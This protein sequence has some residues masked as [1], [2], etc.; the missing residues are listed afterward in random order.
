MKRD[1]WKD[2]CELLEQAGVKITFS[3]YCRSGLLARCECWRCRESRSEPVTPESNA[4]SER[5]ADE[6]DAKHRLAMKEWLSRSRATG[7][8]S[9]DG[10]DD[11]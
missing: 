1:T 4:L 8:E 6:A 3:Q 11:D 10:D 2:F 5:Q 9:A 7:D